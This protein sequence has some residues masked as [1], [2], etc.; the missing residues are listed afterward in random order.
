MHRILAIIL[1]LAAVTSCKRIDVTT[2]MVTATRM[3]TQYQIAN[4][5][6]ENPFCQEYHSGLAPDYTPRVGQVIVGNHNH[7]REW[8]LFDSCWEVIDHQ[9]YGFV[10]FDVSAFKDNIVR[11]E[12]VFQREKPSD[13][14]AFQ[15]YQ[16]KKDW[17]DGFVETPEPWHVQFPVYAEA[18]RTKH[19]VD[20]VPSSG[21]TITI[22]VTDIVRSWVRKD[23]T[24]PP[25]RGFVILPMKFNYPRENSHTLGFFGGFRL[26][27]TTPKP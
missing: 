3:G 11:A 24:R 22:D 5:H 16:P 2:T 15:I 10:F 7:Y 12:L 26:M 17:K 18:E 8:G 21:S 14:I 6:D 19:Y 23:A 25:N 1:V 13:A 27:I 4:Y 9:Y 20:D